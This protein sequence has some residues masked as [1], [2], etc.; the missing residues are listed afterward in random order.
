MYG[1]MTTIALPRAAGE[2]ASQKSAKTRNDFNP[3]PDIFDV[4]FRVAL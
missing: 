4:L 1:L 2:Y 3:A